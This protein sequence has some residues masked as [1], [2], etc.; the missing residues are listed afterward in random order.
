MVGFASKILSAISSLTLKN[1]D[2]QLLVWRTNYLSTTIYF[3]MCFFIATR[4]THPTNRPI[5]ALKLDA[6]P[7]IDQTPIPSL[8]ASKTF[9]LQQ[10]VGA[11]AVGAAA[12]CAHAYAAT[13]QR[14]ANSWWPLENEL[15]ENMQLLLVQLRSLPQCAWH[16]NGWVSFFLV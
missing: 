6:E 15:L 3:A 5:V 1:K 11:M 13:A 16:T 9:L 4:P 8:R 10:S 14:A 7:F 2:I 12:T